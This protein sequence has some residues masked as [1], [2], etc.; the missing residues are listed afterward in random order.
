MSM[1]RI[2]LS[3]SKEKDSRGSV[4]FVPGLFGTVDIFDPLRKSYEKDGGDKPYLFSVSTHPDIESKRQNDISRL[5]NAK[6]YAQPIVCIVSDEQ[7]DQAHKSFAHRVELVQKSISEA[8][9]LGDITIV[10]HSTGGLATLSAV[11]QKVREYSKSYS[12]EKLPKIHAILIAPS[13]A[14][15]IGLSTL[16]VELGFIKVVLRDFLMKLFL[17]GSGRS[18]IVS[19]LKRETINPSLSDFKALV[20]E[21]E[22]KDYLNRISEG[23]VP[24]DGG[25]GRDL[26]F[27][28]KVLEDIKIGD[29][30]DNIKIDVVIPKSDGWVNM[31]GQEKL[32]DDVLISLAGG[33]VAKHKV[34]GGHIPMGNSEFDDYLEKLV[35]NK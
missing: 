1:E 2:N 32:V 31:K 28:P 34:N 33:N 25:E 6:D 11:A 20:G 22:D 21:I 29:W 13:V 30:P 7:R 23:V 19:L 10:G 17:N 18:Y 35:R 24:L 8:E 5:E 12:P 15:D 27:P 4:I 16:P 26:V 14:G 3:E 9:K